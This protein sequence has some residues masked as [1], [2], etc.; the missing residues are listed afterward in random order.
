MSEMK[1]RSI[2]P[3]LAN[4]AAIGVG[5]LVFG[6]S[7]SVFAASFTVG[8]GQ[9]RAEI[10]VAELVDRYWEGRRADV[11]QAQRGRSTLRTQRERRP[12]KEQ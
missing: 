3:H 4:V 6:C 11:D 1:H 8:D 9:P 7:A 10:I 5:P 2:L 12:V